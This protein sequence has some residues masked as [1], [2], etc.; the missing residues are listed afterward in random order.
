MKV[1]I[2]KNEQT[3]ALKQLTN[4]TVFKFN[5]QYYLKISIYSGFNIYSNIVIDDFSPDITVTPCDSSITVVERIN[6]VQRN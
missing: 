4:G 1:T 3:A 2:E 6:C 5:G